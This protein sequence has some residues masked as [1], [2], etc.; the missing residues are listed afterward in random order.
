M[1]SI[2]WKKTIQNGKIF[3]VDLFEA[4]LVPSPKNKVLNKNVM[5]DDKAVIIGFGVIEAMRKKNENLDNIIRRVNKVLCIAETGRN[6]IGMVYGLRAM[7]FNDMKQ[8][9][10]CLVDIALA[11]K[12]GLDANI[13]P[14][15]EEVKHECKEILRCVDRKESTVLDEPKF[16]FPVDEKNPCFA[17]G[18]EV[19]QSKEFGKHIVT[20][21]NLEIGQTVIIEE[22]FCMTPEDDECYSQ[23]A[24][25][26]ARVANLI[27][28]KNCTAAMFCSQKC[29]DIG[30][31]IECGNPGICSQLKPVERLVL[32]TVIKAIEMFPNVKQLMDVVENCINQPTNSELNYTDPTMRAYI[33]F[34]G[35]SRNIEKIPIV[36]GFAFVGGAKT[37]HAIITSDS[38]YKS[39][40]ESPETSQF[41]GHLIL[42]HIYVVGINATAPL[43]LLHGPYR[44][45]LGTNEVY[46]NGNH[47]A[48]ATYPNSS[49]LNHSCQ[50]NIARIFIGNKLIGKVIRPIKRGEQLFVSYL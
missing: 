46:A 37:I 38:A 32:K 9:S 40:F 10:S 44:A 8:Y 12:C 43:T 1:E 47:Y 36:H 24:N 15:L 13:R 4:Y 21:R 19:K 5:K 26:F 17:R 3:Y 18:L 23:C 49:R 48:W 45:E 34:F 16:S 2:L 22:A 35:L 30:H 39:S 27:P 20:N 28:C 41:L 7:L 50:P 25:C 31:A 14:N 29:Q 42:H 6:T 33:T 11:E